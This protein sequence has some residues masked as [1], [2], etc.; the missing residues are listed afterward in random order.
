M[1]RDKKKHKVQAAKKKR[2]ERL[3]RGARER[4]KR[5]EKKRNQKRGWET[6]RDTQRSSLSF[7]RKRFLKRHRYNREKTRT[8]QEK[9]HL[10]EELTEVRVRLTVVGHCLEGVRIVDVRRRDVGRGLFARHLGGQAQT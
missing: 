9:A 7:C 6:K 8:E 5:G 4:Q 10:Y 1:E 2:F 3:E